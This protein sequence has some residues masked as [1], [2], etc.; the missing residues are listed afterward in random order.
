MHHIEIFANYNLQ[1]F[2]RSKDNKNLM[3]LLCE[4]LGARAGSFNTN[5]VTHACKLHEGVPGDQAPVDS[6]CFKKQINAKF[7]VLHV[8]DEYTL[9]VILPQFSGRLSF[10]NLS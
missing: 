9:A 7:N 1:Q 8:T 10:H 5:L 6:I 2:H 4:N 3:P